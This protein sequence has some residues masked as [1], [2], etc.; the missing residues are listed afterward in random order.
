[1]G[2]LSAAMSGLGQGMAQSGQFLMRVRADEE[3]EKRLQKYEKEK[4][5]WQAGESDR[6]QD[7]A[8]QI[9]YGEG[10]DLSEGTAALDR[11]NRMTEFKNMMPLRVQEAG[12]TAG[13]KLPH[14]LALEEG[15]NQLEMQR[16]AAKPTSGGDAG[17]KPPGATE[18]NH[19]RGWISTIFGGS[20]DQFGNMMLPPDSREKAMQ[21]YETGVELM[22]P[23]PET[24]RAP[25]D[26]GSA[27]AVATRMAG[28]TLSEQDARRLAKE[29]A[30]N[31]SFGLLGGSKRDDWIDRRAQ[32]LMEQSRGDLR[33]SLF[34]GGPAGGQPAASPPNPEGLPQPSSREEMMQLPSGTRFMTPD[35]RT[36]VAP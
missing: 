24:G 16:D 5:E 7:R 9:Q 10:A 2:L 18:L 14:Q 19:L 15:K 3:K 27:V 22:K 26:L 28:M 11:Q 13:A 12:D 8:L 20:M 30:R 6:V 29:E 36:G 21:A 4:R 34:G 33:D 17:Y 32:E 23:D 31:E 35:G 1:M 25:M